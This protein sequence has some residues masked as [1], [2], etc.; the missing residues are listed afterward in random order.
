V[1]SGLYSAASGIRIAEMN[2]EM[3]AHNLSNLDTPGYRGIV[4]AVFSI[5]VPQQPEASPKDVSTVGLDVQSIVRDFRPGSQ[6]HTERQLDVAL[7]GDGFFTVEG[8]DGP[9]YTRNGVFQRTAE[10]Q[11]V[12]NAGYPVMGQGGPITIPPEIPEDAVVILQDGTV[13]AGDATIDQLKLVNVDDPHKLETASDTLFS[14]GEAQL[15]ASSATVHQGYREHSNVNATDELVKM[16]VGMRL[17]EASQRALRSL[18]DAIRQH[19]NV[20]GA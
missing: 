15:T 19:I 1:L 6:I 9:L 10:G 20:D 16:I 2:Q 18:S 17:H 12:T 3:T 11:L 4:S 8:P 14:Q 13:L 7:S 5:P